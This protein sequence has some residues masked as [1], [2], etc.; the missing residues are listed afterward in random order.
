M[1]YVSI[2][3]QV[4]VYG[5]G[6]V[7]TVMWPSSP[8]AA[9]EPAE[10]ETAVVEALESWSSFATTGLLGELASA[11]SH[12]GPQY[13][14]LARESPLG[15]PPLT[16][17]AR[18]IETGSIEGDTATVS[19]SVRASR[20]GYVAETY[21][22]TFTLVRTGLTWQVW[23]VLPATAE[24]NSEPVTTTS[25]SPTPQLSTEGRESGPVSMIAADETE[26][27]GLR[28]PALSAWILVI[29][30]VG[31]AAAGYLAPRIDKR[32]DQ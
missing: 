15:D 7:A 17:S 8:A 29:T 19:A 23:T 18:E 14:Q 24:A 12:D 11:F 32:R 5:A 22:W 9:P 6:S 16:L 30:I 28:I 2:L 20:E 26:P 21:E 3:L 31:V 13:G 27:S 10:P 1:L 4:L 25:H